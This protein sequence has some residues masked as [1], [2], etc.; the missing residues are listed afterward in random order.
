MERVRDWVTRDTT[1]GLL[2]ILAAAVALVW[3]NSP[4]RGAYTSLSQFT[5]GPAA[6]H[7]DL[8]LAQWAADGLL[9]IFFFTVGLELKH[10]FVDGSLRSPKQAALPMIA[11]VGGMAAPALVFTAVVLGLGQGDAAGGW[12][13]PTATDIAFAVGV[14]ALFGKGIPKGVRMFLLTLAVVDDL[15]AIIIIAIFYT[16]EIH[17]VWLLVSFAVVAVFAVVART[18]TAPWW[19]LI[20]LAFVAWA[21]MHA[22]GV[23]ATIAG[24][25][26]GFMVPAVAVHGERHTRTHHYN[27]ILNPFTNGLVL[28]IFAFFS[29]GVNLVDG[30]GPAA[31]LGQPV[32]LAISL[33]LV[34][35][36]FVGVLGTT[37]LFT[38]ITPLRLP[39]GLGMRDMLPVGFL[40]GIGFTVSLL[41]AE[42]SFESGT[43]LSDG[44]RIS[45]LIGT[46]IS[47]VLSAIVLRAGSRRYVPGQDVVDE[48]SNRVDDDPDSAAA[49]DHR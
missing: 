22:S 37:A 2:L 43:A 13:I 42:L 20:P 41:I 8:S 9:A 27:S 11:A 5:I 18:R 4:V 19:L 48:H 32:V 35:G 23:H 12:A 38:A 26:L 17:A 16:A 7:L 15:L 39:D 3:A 47:A 28:P 29:A 46:L 31:V 45:V 14:L 33:A 10:E 40:A 6:L 44:A 36:K 21:T 1:A 30:G 34:L 24:V 25:L 49:Q